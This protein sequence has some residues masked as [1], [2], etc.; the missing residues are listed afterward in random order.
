MT[1]KIKAAE[2]RIKACNEDIAALDEAVA[3]LNVQ[4]ALTLD[5][6]GEARGDLR[7]ARLERDLTLPKAKIKITPRYYKPTFDDVIIVKNTGKTITVRTAGSSLTG[8][9]YR[10]ARDGRWWSYPQSKSP[11]SSRELIFEGGAS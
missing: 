1:E 10:L 6:L 8:E 11:Y 4:R 7:D 5:K 2:A 3:A 9:Q